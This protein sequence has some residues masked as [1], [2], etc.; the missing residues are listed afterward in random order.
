MPMF[1]KDKAPEHGTLNDD[2]INEF[3]SILDMINL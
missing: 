1:K 2:L 3:E